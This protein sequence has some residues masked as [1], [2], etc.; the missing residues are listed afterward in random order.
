MKAVAEVPGID[1]HALIPIQQRKNKIPLCPRALRYNLSNR[2]EA[3]LYVAAYSD[4]ISDSNKRHGI[5]YG[6]LYKDE[7]VRGF[8]DTV[9]FT[10]EAHFNPTESFQQPRI[11][12][13]R[14][15]RLARGNVCTQTKRK[16]TPLTLYMY[17]SVNW[18][19]KSPL[20]FYNNKVDM[21]KPPKPPRQLVKSK[22][23]TAAQHYK[24]VKE[25][26]AKLPPP[27]KVKGSGHHMTQEYYTK[28]VLLS[29]IKWVHEA[30]LRE[31][32]SWYLQEDND[33]SHGTKSKDNVAENLRQANWIAV[34]VHP[35]QR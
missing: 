5:H 7:P 20:R 24:W 4:E 28:N 34:I 27:L 23:E 8:W 17:A 6:E 22:Y 18:Y 15:E 3:H 33:P 13:R 30:Q 32:Q 25:W 12:R 29:Y 16:S 21:L 35:G 11:L 14:G 2:E 10:D 31:P 9:Y 1:E 19:F 26:E